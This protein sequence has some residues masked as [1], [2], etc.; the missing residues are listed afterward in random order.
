M[1]KYLPGSASI[2]LG[3]FG[4]AMPLERARRTGGSISYTAPENVIGL[5][6][7]GGLGDVFSAG[8]VLVEVCC[9]SPLMPESLPQA[10]HESSHHTQYLRRQWA[11]LYHLVLLSSLIEQRP[12]YAGK[13]VSDY[14]GKMEKQRIIEVLRT[15]F[16]Q[17]DDDLCSVIVSICHLANT[18][19][20]LSDRVDRPRCATSNRGTLDFIVSYARCLLDKVAGLQRGP[21]LG[22]R[23]SVWSDL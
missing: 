7:K 4:N 23:G 17:F 8:I 14:F 22:T 2:K 20:T 18:P 21:P 10:Y 5:V 11:Q 12:V 6:N 19:M 1:V 3:D 15:Q 9:Q 13:V 16:P